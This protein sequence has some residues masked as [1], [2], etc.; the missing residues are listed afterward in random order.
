MTENEIRQKVVDTAKAWLGYK[1]SNGTHKEIINTY[2]SH[3]PLA[4]GYKVTYTD[5]WCATYVSAVGIKCGL[6]DIMFTE[7]SCPQMINL[8]SKAV[9]WVESDSYVAK[10][11]DIVMYDWQDSGSGDNRGTADHVGIVIET[12]GS[13]MTIIEGNLNYAVGT[14]KLAVNGKYIR[15][16]CIPDYASKANGKNDAIYTVDASGEFESKAEAEKAL[17]EIQ[18]LGFTGS[19]SS[20]EE[21]AKPR[22]IEKGDTVRVKRGA[23]FYDGVTPNPVVYDRNHVVYSIKGTR[24]VIAVGKTIIGAVHTDN[25][26]LV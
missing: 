7:C 8:Y 18:K 19:V 4:R 6:T 23:K 11:A 1:Q 16:Y 20:K 15:G 17:T 2:N 25:L 12:D 10:V 9:R 26:T 22:A 24:A 5:A 21:E 14:R 3:K 13:T